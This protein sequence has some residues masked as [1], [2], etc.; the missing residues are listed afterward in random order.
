MS[1][2][3]TEEP[4]P[5][6]LRDARQRGEV[7][8]SR[9]LGSAVVLLG[10][11]GVLGTSAASILDA[12][13]ATFRLAIDAAGRPDAAPGAVL[14]ASISLAL[15]AL[16]PL[17]AAMVVLAALSSLVQVGPLWAPEA[18]GWKPERLDPIQGA[19]NLFT[20][21]R[22][23]DLLKA[24][25]GIAVALIVAWITVRD[26]MRGTIALAGRDALAALRGGGDLARTLMLRVGMAMLALAV[27]DVVYQRWRWMRDQRMTKDEVKREHKEAEGD[28]H[29]KQQRERLRH[30]IAQHD[31]LE[32]V[33][34]A[35]VLVVNP[36]HLA[37]ALRFD[38]ESEQAA[39]E[40]VAKGQDELARRMI[41]VAREAGV[42]V[43]Q[44][45]PLAHG[46]FS[47]DVGEE[48]PEALYEAVAAV[49]RAAWSEREAEP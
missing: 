45:V 2:E 4:T 20:Q 46:L 23:V 32:Q 14:E 39:P 9:E 12:H 49:L 27:L 38:E 11:A 21:R 6:R 34:R 5:K 40:V 13:T 44:D 43:M 37:V 8:K 28:P 1:G 48:I 10:A 29:V 30:E 33:R 42:P 24:L 16:A 22:L 7:W 36:T 41:D 15:G 17:F 35:D 25:I 47:L 31:T 19:K 18:I 26:G 3:K